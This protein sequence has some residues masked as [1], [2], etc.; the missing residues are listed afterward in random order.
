LFPS[1]VVL[2]EEKV[3]VIEFRKHNGTAHTKIKTEIS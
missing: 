3:W 2:T 1:K